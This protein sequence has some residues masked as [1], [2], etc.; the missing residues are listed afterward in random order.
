MNTEII[1]MMDWKLKGSCR[2]EIA[3]RASRGT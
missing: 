3:Q 1:L 2:D